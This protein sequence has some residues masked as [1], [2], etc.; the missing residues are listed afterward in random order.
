MS[1]QQRST[2]CEE[3][4]ELV[5]SCDPNNPDPE[6]LERID[7]HVEQCPDCQSAESVM[8][9]TVRAFREA[10]PRGVSTSFEEA[11]VDQ[12]C[13]NPERKDQV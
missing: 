11:L 2:Y 4:A 9:D 12:L 7:Q 5:A 1:H 10:E 6:L 8:S 13:Q 3:L